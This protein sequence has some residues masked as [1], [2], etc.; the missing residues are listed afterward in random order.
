M[1]EV[2]NQ[3]KKRIGFGREGK[4]TVCCNAFDQIESLARKILDELEEYEFDTFDAG[5]R[6]YG[7]SK[8]MQDFLREKFGVEDTLK[9]HFRSEF[10]RKLSEISGRKRKI[11]G[12]INVI[13]NLENL[14]Y[15]I[16]ISPVFI[17]GRYKKRVRFLSQT[18]WLCGDCGGKGCERCN[19]TGRKYLS[20]EDLIIQPALELFKGKNAFLHGSGREDVDARMLGTGRPFI[21]EIESPKKRK[22]DLNELET[23]INENA[24]GKIEVEFFF[25]TERRAVEKIKKAAYSKTYRAIISLEGDV[26]FE[27]LEKALKKLEEHEISQRTPQRVE[28]RRADKVRKRK[29][30]SIRLLLKKGRKAVVTIH[31]ESGLYIKELISGDEGRTTPS[32]SELL[33][34]DCRVEKL[35]V[36]S[37]NGGLED[38]NLKYNPA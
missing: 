11:G 30:Y 17:Y 28:H 7:S 3:C 22:V 29:V 8:A 10:I 2:C 9:E 19:Y 26:D 14:S 31:A 20:V 15:S 35:D 16:E 5:I 24:G 37:I 13:V 12:D 38:G 23:A 18:R 21:L 33:G 36:L 27:K 25:Y 1:I 32:L 6:L 34:V 4:C